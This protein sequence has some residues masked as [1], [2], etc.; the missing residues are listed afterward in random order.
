[1]FNARRAASGLTFEQLAEASG[2]TGDPANYTRQSYLLA[3]VLAQ[4]GLLDEGTS[5]IVLDT[6]TA[7]NPDVVVQ[8][9]FTAAERPARA[10]AV[11]LTRHVWP[12]A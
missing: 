10:A 12:K 3:T 9:P 5:T 8:D 1:M 7:A 4:A 2:Q 11:N 6:L